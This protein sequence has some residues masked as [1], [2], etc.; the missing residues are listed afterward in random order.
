M[1]GVV[2]RVR[3]LNGNGAGPALGVLSLGDAWAC[4]N[5]SMGR[6]MALGLVHAGICGASCAST[7][8]GP[9]E[10]V[11]RFAA[12]DRNRAAAV[13]RQHGARRP[14][15]DGADHRAAQRRAPPSPITPSRARPRARA[16][17]EPR[18]R[19]LPRRRGDLLLPALP[20]EVFARPG[21]VQRVLGRGA[22][23][24]PP[25]RPDR[26]ELWRCWRN[27]TR[28]APAPAPGSPPRLGPMAERLEADVVRARLEVGAD[29]VRDLLRRAVRDHRV[30][31]AV[32][33]AVLDVALGVAELEQVARVVVRPR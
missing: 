16:G 33:A 1:G 20:R 22:R 15:A 25:G 18:P 24:A 7:A 30:D 21:I 14:R 2:D 29:R 27:F 23:R 3:S 9:S 6:G 26:K 32:R 10:L 28:A 12:D 5:P 4:T 31:Q 17:D 13:V 8:T 19:C 11:A